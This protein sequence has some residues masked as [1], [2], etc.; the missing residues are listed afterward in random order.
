MIVFKKIPAELDCPF[1]DW[2]VDISSPFFDTWGQLGITANYLT[3]IG[4]IIQLI[5]CFFLAKRYGLLAGFLWLFGYYFDA[6][7]GCYARYHHLASAYGDI[8]DHGKDWL[9]T[10]ILFIVIIKYYKWRTFDTIFWALLVIMVG[11]F[12]G[13]QEQY[14]HTMKNSDISLMLKPVFWVFDLLNLDPVT[15]L[16]TWLRWFGPGNI[17]I[18]VSIYLALLP[19]RNRASDT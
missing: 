17:N 15:Q 7:D 3:I 4:G 11:L 18:A 9:C 1:D 16:K 8:L 6:I 2:M 12:T 13:A 10:I 19:I 14:I 5:A